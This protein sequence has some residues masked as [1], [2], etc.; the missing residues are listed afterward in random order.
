MILE[1][2]CCNF[3]YKTVL[4]EE[5]KSYPSQ[6][7]IQIERLVDDGINKTINRKHIN[8]PIDELKVSHKTYLLTGVISLEGT[9][10]IIYKNYVSN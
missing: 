7:V 8:F 5:M 2:E 1:Q 10:S 9:S 6:L 4:S 3:P